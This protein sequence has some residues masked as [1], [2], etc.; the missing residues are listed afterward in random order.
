MSYRGDLIVLSLTAFLRMRIQFILH[1]FVCVRV[2]ILGFKTEKR[3]IK[4]LIL[5]YRFHIDFYNI[6]KTTFLIKIKKVK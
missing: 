3:E 2:K 1:V 4:T 5:N 6:K